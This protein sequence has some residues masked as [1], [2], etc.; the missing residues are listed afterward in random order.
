MPIVGIDLKVERVRSKVQ[1]KDLAREMGVS[2]ATLYN[3]EQAGAVDAQRAIQY[4]EA[5]ARIVD[6]RETSEREAVAS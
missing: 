6:V 3:I 5:V 4:R 1:A 2:R